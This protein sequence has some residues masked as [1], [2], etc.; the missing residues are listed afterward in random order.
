MRESAEAKG[1][2]LLVEGRLV[3]KT[4]DDRHAVARCRGDS[5]EIYHLVAEARGWTCSC[6]ALGRCSHVIALQLVTLRSLPT[7]GPGPDGTR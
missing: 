1:R 6:P 5:G 3:V 4:V 7:C 2:R